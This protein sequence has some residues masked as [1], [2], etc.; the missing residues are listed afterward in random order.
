MKQAGRTCAVAAAALALIAASAAGPRHPVL[1]WNV[2][3][4]VPLGLYAVVPSSRP[5]VG[6]LVAVRPPAELA[7]WLA[8]AGYLRRDLALLK[9]L[10][11]RAGAE[12]CRNAGTIRIDGAAVAIARNRDRRGRPLPVWDGCRTL[13]AGEVFLLNAEEAASLDGRYFGRLGEGTIMGRAIPL[14]TRD[15]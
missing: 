4:S 10:A 3:A 2:S 9:H 15:G 11:A 7:R 5:R 14:W 1:V 13:A 12:V 8:G 6:D